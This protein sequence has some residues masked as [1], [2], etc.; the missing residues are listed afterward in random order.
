TAVTT[1]KGRPGTL[2]QRIESHAGFVRQRPKPFRQRGGQ[3]D[4]LNGVA[5][6]LSGGFAG[7]ASDWQ[8]RRRGETFQ[9]LSPKRLRCGQVTLLQPLDVVAIRPRRLQDRTPPVIK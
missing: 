8:R 5:C 3:D 1:Q 7:G 4:L 2:K 6:L 9:G